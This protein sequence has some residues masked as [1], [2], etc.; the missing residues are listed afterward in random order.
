MNSDIFLGHE[1]C[2][3]DELPVISV[4]NVQERID[5]AKKQLEK[6]KI[7]TTTTPRP[8]A[9]LK[10]KAVL[11]ATTLVKTEGNK[12]FEITEMN[13]EEDKEEE[14]EDDDDDDDSSFDSETEELESDEEENEVKKGKRKQKKQQVEHRKTKNQ[15]DHKRPKKEV[16]KVLPKRS[17]KKNKKNK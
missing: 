1:S 6:D 3:D 8:T 16:E 4:K 10:P 7:G 9:V 14:E 15:N 17:K 12:T 5:R 2:Y 11:P 13:S